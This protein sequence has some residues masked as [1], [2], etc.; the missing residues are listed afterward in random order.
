[1]KL[2]RVCGIDEARRRALVGPLVATAVVLTRSP[3]KISRLA[4]T[5]L[6]DGKLLTAKQR[7]KIFSVLKKLKTEMMIEVISSRQ[8]NNHNIGWANRKVVRRLIKKVDADK[9]II[10]GC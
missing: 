1:M 7:N 3:Q 4:K 2:K 5:K 10:D 8:I 6:R 9:Y